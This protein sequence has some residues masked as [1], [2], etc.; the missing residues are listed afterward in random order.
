MSR[1][2]KYRAYDKRTNEMIYSSFMIYANGLFYYDSGWDGVTASGYRRDDF[3]VMD[4][5]GIKDTVNQTEIYEGD[6]VKTRYGTRTVKW[7]DYCGA[8][9]LDD[10]VELGHVAG[11]REVVGNI[12]EK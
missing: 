10:A 3:I 1:E 12:Y 11:P 7:G 8:W 5:T 6:R 2:R 9:T 4:Y